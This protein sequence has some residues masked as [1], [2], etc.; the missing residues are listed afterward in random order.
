MDW[1]KSIATELATGE[2]DMYTAPRTPDYG[3]ADC[4]QD[5]ED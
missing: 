3:A 5:L 2:R 1:T 4:S